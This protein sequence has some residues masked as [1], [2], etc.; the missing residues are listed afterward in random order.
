MGFLALQTLQNYNFLDLSAKFEVLMARIKSIPS[1]TFISTPISS[2]GKTP[3][4][5]KRLTRSVSVVLMSVL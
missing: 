3:R 2:A 4:F 1:S 5:V